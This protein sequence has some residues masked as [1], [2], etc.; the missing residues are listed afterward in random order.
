MFNMFHPKQMFTKKD[1]VMF[2]TGAQ[3][4][5]TLTHIILPFT[6]CM[7]IKFMFFT[8]GP[9]F[10]IAAIVINLVATALLFWWASKL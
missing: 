9:T 8:V 7:P 6:N 10:N 1:W 2:A 5:H 4:F 3:A